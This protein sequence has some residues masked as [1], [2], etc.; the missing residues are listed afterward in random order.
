M[1]I[2]PNGMYVGAT[3]SQ[4][5]EPK[6]TDDDLC[7]FCRWPAELLSKKQL[8]GAWHTVNF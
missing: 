1:P 2:V 6:V 4:D 7:P 5:P 3:C 8:H